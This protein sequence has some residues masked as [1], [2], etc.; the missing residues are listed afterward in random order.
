MLSFGH[1]C[2]IKYQ[3]RKGQRFNRIET[4][5]YILHQEPVTRSMQLPHIPVTAFS[6]TDLFLA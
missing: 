6:Q 4:E 5:V 3:G 1:I 2:D